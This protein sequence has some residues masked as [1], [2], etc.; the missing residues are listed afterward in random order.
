MRAR[1]QPPIGIATTM[2]QTLRACL[3]LGWLS[4]LAIIIV[5]DQSARAASPADAA[6]R[7]PGFATATGT[8]VRIEDADRILRSRI[9]TALP[10]VAPAPAAAGAAGVRAVGCGAGSSQP[11]EI[12]TLAAALKCDPD[13]IFEYVYN[14][15]EYEPLFGGNKGPLGALLD[16]RGSDI[17]QAQ[18]FTA[19]LSAAGFSA[20]S[21]KYEYGYIRLNGAQATGWLAVKNDGQAIGNVFGNGGIPLANFFVNPDGTLSSIDVAHVWVQLQINGTTYVFDPSFKQHTVAL[22]LSNLGSVL[23]YTQSPFLSDAGGTT[24][25]V[26]VANLSRPSIRGDLVTYSSNLI[27][28][29]KSHNPAWTLNDVVGGKTIKYLTGSPLRQ[30]SLPYLSPSQPSGFPQNWGATVPDAYRT[31]FTVSMPGVAKTLCGSASAQTI[32]LYSD[33]TYGHRITIS[34]TGS[35]CAPPNGSCVPKLLIDGQPPPNGQNTGTP[36]DFGQ[37]WTVNVAITHPYTG[38]L[39]TAANQSQ[40]LLINAGGSYLIGAGWGQV[41]RGMVEKHRTLLARARATG[42]AGDSEVVL[43]ESL[44]V[45]S[46]SWLAE[47]ASVQRLGDAIAQITTQYHHGVGITAQTAIQGQSGAQG[48]YVDL[49]M[50]FVTS[51]PQTHYSGSGFPP[52]VVG[53]FFTTWGAASSLEAAVLEQTQALIPGMVAA[54][55]VRLVDINAATAAK[56]FFADGATP[57]GVSA[58]FSSIRPNLASSYSTT[59]LSQVD[60]AVS[61]DGTS[62]GAPTGNQ[63]LAPANGS[64]AVGLWTGAGFTITKQT[65]TSISIAQ[66]ISGG[67]S[68]GFSGTNV[69]T[70]ASGNNPTLSSSTVTEMQPAAGNPAIPAGAAALPA[71]PAD[72][73]TAEPV[74]AVT[75]AYLYQHADLLTGGGAFPYALPFARN[76][77]SASNLTDRGLGNGWA[78]GYG[79]AA[80]RSSDPYRG[81]GFAAPVGAPAAIAGTADMGENSAIDA[82]AAVA[83]IYVSQDLL[84]GAESAKPLTVAWIVNRWLTD[85]LTNNAVMVSWP[86]TSEEFTFLPHADGSPSVTY[87]APIGSAVVLTGSAPDSD[88]NYTSFTYTSKDQ[89]RSPSPGW[90]RRRTGRSP[91]GPFPPGRASASPTATPLAARAI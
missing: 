56:T 3:I 34:S 7:P 73:V 82:A 69:P 8:P 33:Q 31:C 40:G 61:S 76:Y 1:L 91:G 64:I 21:M 59:E 85:Q 15:I 86:M 24:D 63:V 52:S 26:S 37:Q 11:V 81:I 43:G 50:N 60:K 68:G 79:I 49:P 19:L 6:S 74:D 48:P 2:T 65:A 58:Y 38:S 66:K 5:P 42:N 51:Q 71:A 39:A 29:I 83:A 35:S 75:G 28:Y 9:A 47:V 17:D 70:V 23:R 89:S 55:T 53:S 67:L 20:A 27:G 84:K 54:S 10:S 80:A 16:L 32:Q 77:S 62:M 13:L 36:A 44:A 25:S 22:Q 90:A 57:T 14:N 45:I 88:G 41:G 4:A 78:S 72:P 12:A 30:T 87:S 18:L 46:Y